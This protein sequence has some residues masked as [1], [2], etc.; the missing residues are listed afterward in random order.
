MNTVSY[1]QFAGNVG[2]TH[3][4]IELYVLFQQK[5]VVTAVYKPTDGLQLVL[6]FV[7]G[8]FQQGDARIVVDAYAH[9]RKLV[10]GLSRLFVYAL[11][12]PCKN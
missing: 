2:R 12:K 4:Q 7:R 8:V 9:L 10:V 11:V 6:C 1:S 5:I 3:E